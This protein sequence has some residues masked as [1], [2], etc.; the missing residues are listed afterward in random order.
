[1]GLRAW[2][3]TRFER[4]FR[5]WF[6]DWIQER[7]DT[8]FDARFDTRFDVR[9]DAAFDARF[10]TR[11]DAAFDARFDTRHGGAF[12]TR[13]ET[14]LKEWAETRLQEEF[15]ARVDHWFD[16][17]FAVFADTWADGAT[18][19]QRLDDHFDARFDDQLDVRA[20]ARVAN[21]I[22]D[23]IDRRIEQWLI[24]THEV[25]TEAATS[26]PV[27]A[28]PSTEPAG[29][30]D[31]AAPTA[32]EP[33]P[34]ESTVTAAELAAYL[35][36]GPIQ[37]G[38]IRKILKGKERLHGRTYTYPLGEAAVAVLLRKPK[39]ATRARR[40]SPQPGHAPRP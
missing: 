24:T 37:V 1:M 23:R 22:E 5:A 9:H 8:C 33:A 7:F 18:L 11:H 26:T 6:E 40:A 3:E 35:A 31:M 19:R 2:I 25:L 39:H 14:R 34:A 36:K 12:D 15:D 27:P 32:S 13:F 21:C 29:Q 28:S 16:L 30:T 4:W 10:E 20:K 17:R 38:Q